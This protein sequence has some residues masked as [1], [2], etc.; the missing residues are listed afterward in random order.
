MKFTKMQG[1]GNDYVY[2]NCFTEKLP[3][4]LPA[5]SV[6]LSDR[7][8][9][10]GSDGIILIGPSDR[11]DF[12]MR[13]YNA[14]GSQAQMCGNGIRCVGKYVYDKGMIDKTTI[15]V[16]TLGGIKT[17]ELFE[18]NSQIEKV[19]VNMGTP[20]LDPVNIRVVVDTENFIDQPVLVAGETWHV[21]AVNV[22]NPHAVTFVD[23]VDSLD[24]ASIGP[25]F[26]NHHL[27]PERI[28]TEFVQVI[29]DRHLKMRVWERGSNETMACG[30]GAT[31]TLV[32]GVLTGRCQRSAI[33]SLRGGDLEID[34]DESTNSLYMTGPAAIS[35]E[36]EI[37]L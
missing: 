4:D 19:K 29:D 23:D 16:E 21:T 12:S 26:E 25:L 28:N 5:L 30:T 31:A 2:I 35:F 32:A 20:I 9:A 10:I 7:H 37:N 6:R 14:D 22:G 15:T 18:K 8:F 33:V 11:A 34:W 13:I 27:F 36:G 17:L 1:I 24:L 3:Q